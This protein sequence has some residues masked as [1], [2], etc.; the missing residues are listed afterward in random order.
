MDMQHDAIALLPQVFPLGGREI[1]RPGMQSIG[2]IFTC[3]A[4]SGPFIQGA[5]AMRKGVAVPL[6]SLMLVASCRPRPG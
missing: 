3:A 4:R 2:M 5:P 1:D 6:P